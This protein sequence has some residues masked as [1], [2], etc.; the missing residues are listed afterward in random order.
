[1]TSKKPTSQEIRQIFVD[2]FKRN[3]HTHVASSSLIPENDPTLL[4][5][6]AGMNQFKNAFLGLEKRDYTRAVTVQKCVRAGG[7]HNDLENV[8]FTARHHTFFEMLGNFSFGD[9]FKKDAIRFAWEL[10]TKDLGIPKEKLYVTV[11]ESDDEAADIWHKQEGVPKD[12][13]FRLGEK[14][15]FWRM[16]DT[17]PCGPCSE[18]FYDHGPRAGRESD[19]FKGIV[20]GEDRYVEI[21]NLVFMQF[22]EKSPGVM[23]PLPKP[24]VDTGSGLERVVAAMQGKM[25]NYDTDLFTPMIEAACKIA[26]WDFQKLLRLEDKLRD[27]PLGT[28]EVDG[29]S[30]QEVKENLAA[31][32]VMADHVRSSATLIADGAMPA[33]EGRGYV[34]RRIL[35]RAIRYGRKVSDK[36]SFLPRLAEVYIESMGSIYPE[37]KNRRDVVMATIEDEESR[38]LQTLDTGTQILFDELKRLGNSKKVPGEFVFKLYDTYGFP[39]DLTRVMS[40][41]KGFS[42]DESEF[43]LHMQK[44]RELAKAS[45][46]GK[47]MSADD[48][49]MIAW[50]Q[51]LKGQSGATRFTGYETLKDSANV[52]AL[53][54]G[55]AAV[56]TLK[57]GETGVLVT[58]VT[59]FYA[60][61][62]GQI[63]DTGVIESTEGHAK[64]LDTTKK[65]DVY[66]HQIE[67]TSGSFKT[68]QP[69]TLQVVESTRRQIAN[70]H[71]AT[72]L[73]HSALRKFLGTHVTQAGSLVDAEKTRFDFSHNKPVTKE[74][75]EKIETWVNEQIARAIPVA[76]AVMPYKK[77][78]E[79]GA[80]ALFG[81]KYG[82]EVRVLK[83]DDAST[84]LC[85]GTHVSNTAQIRLF[86]IVSESGVSAGVRRIEAITGDVAQ[87]FLMKHASENQKA[88]H[89]VGLMESWSNFMNSPQD[90]TQWIEASKAQIRDL[91]KQIKQSQSAAVDLDAWV[92]AAGSFA[93][94]KVIATEAPS[95]D[96]EILAK[97]ADQLKDKIQTGVVVLLGQGEDTAPLLVAVSK[98]LNPKVQAGALLKELAGVMGGKGGGRPDFAQGAVPNPK[99]W[100]EA[101]AKLKALLG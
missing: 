3:G 47:S 87:K 71:S 53:S 18:I 24:S 91:E 63:G 55:S 20:A 88:R 26:G 22:F 85:G 79:S 73:M 64:V 33:N 6:N 101:Q 66:L 89:A 93:G 27:L 68:G 51:D 37:L 90:V 54:S 42:V 69:V 65:N 61:G 97:W 39:A 38:F 34:L 30:A 23:E 95:A 52:L 40:E 98:D 50:T 74:E 83:M 4:F 67:V 31:L 45:W 17:G 12:R 62:G 77:A 49:H 92:K 94:G 19:P 99:A 76:P 35:R 43:E 16:G 96:R 80:M 81:E 29:M 25:N 100:P 10:L 75:I 9:Y 72:H 60:E 8:G 84:E 56:D 21:W 57:T 14:D 7:K 1:M 44:A 78:I 28:K 11:F 36:H 13:I 2:Y 5:A 82:D 48:G 59:P 41:E 32:R 86:K 70:N 15:N 46:K 58:A